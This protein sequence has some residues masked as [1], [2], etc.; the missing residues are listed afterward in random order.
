MIKNHTIQ[1]LRVLSEFAKINLEDRN[2]I[3]IDRMHIY[4][5]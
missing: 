4:P 1:G 2:A 5:P 3:T